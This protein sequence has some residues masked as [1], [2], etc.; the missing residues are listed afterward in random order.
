MTSALWPRVPSSSSPPRRA[1]SASTQ[2]S[3]APCAAGSTSSPR[4]SFAFARTASRGRGGA[5]VGGGTERH[6][7]EDD[8]AAAAGRGL[9]GA[10]TMGSP[11]ACGASG[12]TRPRS[13]PPTG[14]ALQRS[15]VT[16]SAAPGG[17]TCNRLP[18][19]SP[20]GGRRGRAWPRSA[21]ARRTVACPAGEARQGR[22]RGEGE[23]QEWH[24]APTCERRFSRHLPIC[25]R[26]KRA[27]TAGAGKRWRQSRAI[28]ERYSAQAARGHR[29]PERAS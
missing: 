18:R 3:V 15:T 23:E 29:P 7:L 25:G 24:S 9:G 14:S 1:S 8:A 26:G 11:A 17:P 5:T 19:R 22:A 13:E 28:S 2:T 21:A 6:R 16:S 10:T 27:A 12:A 4:S 20:H